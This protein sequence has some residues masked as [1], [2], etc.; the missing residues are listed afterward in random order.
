MVVHGIRMAEYN[1]AGLEAHKPIAE[2]GRINSESLFHLRRLL[3]LLPLSTL[4]HT[5]AIRP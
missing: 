1:L 2:I 5:R 4:S 3:A